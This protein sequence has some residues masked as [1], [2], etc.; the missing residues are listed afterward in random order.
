MCRAQLWAHILGV[1]YSEW[2][3][4]K[5]SWKVVCSQHFFRDYFI[6]PECARPN[7]MIDPTFCATSL[8][9]HSAPKATELTFPLP[10]LSSSSP[11]VAYTDYLPV[12][13]TTKTYSTLSTMTSKIFWSI[14]LSIPFGCVNENACDGEIGS[15]SFQSSSSK[16]G[17]LY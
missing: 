8:H 5:L 1:L 6:S 16:Q 17:I 14:E 2:T 4:A 3:V 9:A 12:E 10:P 15:I 13:K 11:L 7:T